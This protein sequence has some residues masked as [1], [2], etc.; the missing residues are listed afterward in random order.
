MS[1]P[2][3]QPRGGENSVE[4]AAETAGAQL[5]KLR[6]T[7]EKAGEKQEDSEARVSAERKKVEAAFGKEKP[8]A[9]KANSETSKRAS[10]A[11]TKQDKKASFNQTM[12]RVQGEMSPAE[13]T[14]SKFIHSPVIEKSSEVI[15]KTI[16][17]PNAIFTGS[18]F[19]FVLVLAVYFLARNYGFRLSGFETIGAF[20]LGWTIGLIYDY[21]RVMAVGRRS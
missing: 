19:A 5:E 4:G 1:N 8:V 3:I 20:A 12:K 10:A 13:R 14:F 18:L 2:E 6:H 16:A 21:V 11:I 7:Q 17:R 15:G 9:E